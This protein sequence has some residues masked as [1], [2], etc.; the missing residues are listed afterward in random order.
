MYV[1]V[2]GAGGLGAYFGARLQLVGHTVTFVARGPHLAAIRR[3]GMR[4]ESDVAPM[5]LRGVHAVESLDGMLK[6]D[7]VIIAVKLWDTIS[8]AEIAANVVGPE[9]T[10]VSFQNGVDAIDSI[11]SVVGLER[12]IGGVAYIS[13]SVVEPGV[14]RQ[15]G[16]LQRLLFGERNGRQTLRTMRFAS[17]CEIAAI[18]CAISDDIE[19]AIWEKFVFIVGLS[20][21]TCLFR[22]SIGPI[23]LHSKSRDLLRALMAETVAV[24]IGAGIRLDPAYAEDRLAFIDTLPPDMIASMLFDLQKERRLELPWFSG[25]V[26]E[27]GSK[28]DIAT[29]ANAFVT[30]ALSLDEQ[31]STPDPLR[32]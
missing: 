27:M 13:A 32:H 21:S 14:I 23:R 31:G 12:M 16:K 28:L 20:A 19:K 3:N 24:G 7:I 4:I 10:V 29:P 1:V 11:G 6:A 17:A 5:V 30:A 8:A 9:T 15:T 2:V 26:V 22:R 18:D 25:R